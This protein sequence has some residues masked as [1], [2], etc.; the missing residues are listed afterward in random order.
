M[1]K[2]AVVIGCLAV[3]FAATGC[4]GKGTPAD[5]AHAPAAAV[6]GVYDGEFFTMTLASGWEAAPQTRGSV[7]VVPK[8]AWVPK[9]SFDF[10]DKGDAPGTAEEAVEAIIARFEGS[11]MESTEIGGVEFK[12]TTYI[13]AGSTLTTH[14]AFRQGTKISISIEHDD[15]GDNPDI[16]TM[17]D[18]VSP[19]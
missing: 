13:F 2:C 9:L 3:I 8:D 16:Q 17:L 1:R 5:S 4:G 14:V 18:S 6:D 11:P 12:T 15:A 10:E 19:K 7:T